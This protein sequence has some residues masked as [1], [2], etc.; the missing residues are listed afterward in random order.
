[1][2]AYLNVDAGFSLRSASNLIVE[3]LPRF[4]APDKFHVTVIVQ[5]LVYLSTA[6]FIFF[7]A[8]KY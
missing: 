5:C 7:I 2:W 1:M 3:L 6:H 4:W 8:I